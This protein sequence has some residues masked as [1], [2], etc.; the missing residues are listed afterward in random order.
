M[1]ITR[2]TPS[3]LLLACGVNRMRALSFWG[4]FVV[5]CAVGPFCSVLR[6]QNYLTSTGV[7]SFTVPYPAEMGTVD[8]ASGNLHLE[9][10]L[11]SFPQRKSSP[12]VPKLLY[13][14]HIW[15]VPSDSVSPTWT[16]QGA[17]YGLAFGTWGFDEG[18]TIGIYSLARGGPN[19]CNDDY[20]MWSNSG[21][22]HYFNIPGY[23]INGDQCSG[24]VAYAADSSG[25]QLTQTAWGSGLDAQVYIYAPDGTEVYGTNLYPNSIASKDS[26]GN[27]LGLTY[28][29]ILPPGIDNPV[30]D[31][32]GRKIVNP[33]GVGETTITLQLM[34]AEGGLSDYIVTTATIP[35]STD[36]EQSGIAECNSSNNCTAQVITSIALP[37]GTSYSFLY[38]CYEAGNSACN[39]PEGQ[40]GY[41]GTL[42]SM[43]LPSGATITYQYENYTDAI[44]NVS[45]WLTYKSS[46]NGLWSYFPNVTSS[47]TQQV[48][49]DKP[50]NLQ[51]VISFTL[52]N[53]AWPTQV[54]TYDL[55]Y[56]YDGPL[57]SLLSTVNNTWDFSIPCTLQI[58]LMQPVAGHQDI[59]KLSTS[60]TLP[61]PTGSITKQTT[62][63][64]DSP[65]TGN[66]T[67]IQEWKYQPGTSPTFPTVPDR[68][69]YSRY[70]TIGSN[71]DIN[72]PLSVTLCNSSGGSG[73]D[74]NCSTGGTSIGGTTVARTVYTYDAYGTNGSLALASVTGVENHDDTNFGVGYTARGNATQI[75]R[76]V[77][78][79]ANG[80]GTYLITA[81][82]YDTTGQVIQVLD[83]NKNATSYLYSDNLYTDN[84]ADPPQVFTPAKPTHAYITTVTDTVGSAS[85][86]YYFGNGSMAL[87]TDYNAVTTYAHYL[88]PFNRPTET[89]YPVG[90]SINQYSLPVQGETEV[91]S[92]AAIGDVKASASCVSCT[93]TQALLD[94]FG[95]VTTGNLVNNPAGEVS[96]NYSY[97]GLNRVVS[98]SHPHIGAGDPNNVSELISY[99]SLG[100]IIGD[101]HPDGEYALSAY[102]ANVLYLG[103]LSAQQASG[104]TYGYGFPVISVDEAGRQKQQWIDGFGRVIEVDE[105]SATTSSPGSGSVVIAQL[106]DIYQNGF[107]VV[108]VNDFI[109]AV[110]YPTSPTPAQ[111]AS[112]IAAGFNGDVLS[113]VNAM[114]NGA[115]VELTARSTGLGTDYSLSAEI[116]CD[117][118][119]CTGGPEYSVTASGASLT[120][121]SGGVTVAPNVTSYIYDVRGNLTGV[122][123]GVQTRT[124]QYDALGR[125]TLEKTPEAST[126]TNGV[127]VQNPVTVS[128]TATGGALCSGKPSNPC[129][130]TDARG[131]ITTY[132]YDTANRLIGKTHNP[133]TTGPETYT[134]G[135]STTAFN[136]GRLKK[137]TDPSGSETYTYDNMGRITSIGKAVGSTTYTTHY[138]YNTG[139]QLT[140]LTYPSGRIVEYSYDKVGHLCIVAVSATA[141]CAS[142][143]SPYLTL[144]SLNYDAASRALNA[145][146]GNGIV[147]TATYDP[148]RSQLTT[149]NYAMGGTTLFGLKY[150]YQK[151]STSCSSGSTVGNDGEIQCIADLS[152]GTGDSGRS[153]AYTY[154]AL[155]RLLT[156]NSAGSTQFPAWGLSE[157]YDRYANRTIQT[158]T[159]GSGYNTSLT[160][161]PASNQVTSPAF[162]YDAGGDVTAEPAPLPAT[163]SYDGESCMIGFIG[164]GNSATYTCDGH[165]VRVQKVVTGTN[166]V[167]TVSIRS[168][169]EV[170]A[171]YDNGA[172]VTSPTREYIFGRHRVATVVGSVSGSGGTITY[173]HRDH[174]SPRLY[175][176]SNG[177][178]TCEQGTYP[179]G[180]AWYKTCTNWIFTTYERDQ[181]SGL[182]YALARSYSSTFGRFMSP[183]PLTGNMFN[184]QRL[185]RYA[186]VLNDPINHIDPTGGDD[187]DD[188]DDDDCGDSC[189]GG[190]SPPPPDIFDF[191][192]LGDFS[193][194]PDS[195]T[196]ADSDLPDAPS[197]TPTGIANM[198]AAAEAQQSGESQQIISVDLVFDA[199]AQSPA[200]GTPQDAP[201]TLSA[202]Q[203]I[204][205]VA[206]FI[207]VIGDFANLAN[208]G[209][210][211][212]QGHYGQALLFGFSAIPVAGVL[213]EIGQAAEVAEEIEQ[214]A[215][216]ADEFVNLASEERTAHIL[217]GDTGQGGHL[218]PGG[219]GKSAFPETWSGPEVMHNVSD[220]ATDPMSTV[221]PPQG[222]GNIAVQGTRG[223]VD[224]QVIIAG[225]NG[226]YSTPANEIVTAFPT[227]VAR[228]PL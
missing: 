157:T 158:V 43:S 178:D 86:G 189:G 72:H 168:G 78:G 21:V 129:S 12:L 118:N 99:D 93:H 23:L 169:G 6:A 25:F 147:A 10:P 173:E 187:D 163:F 90:W 141:N 171:E 155:G 139:G 41:Y 198:Q 18:G 131:V 89:D 164:N 111:L 183:D 161:N 73:T 142:S 174:L 212:A 206:G 63:A 218:F 219:P 137:M 126:T 69:T 94:P 136:I 71:N 30:I 228:N 191:T 124:Y 26:N 208:A 160:I 222:N 154:D 48:V 115:T 130:I 27:Y 29:N 197:A 203:G 84:G 225:P 196:S 70:A 176:D 223:G 32:L 135:T 205:T 148:N 28:G 220:V 36:F 42:T 54:Q 217:D 227:N 33:L 186:Y 39:S 149:L 188:D 101:Q 34:N 11:G 127:T 199:R 140:K 57:Q 110:G 55:N 207:P 151:N 201:S 123:Q 16:T 181:E 224:I 221:A 51:D 177:N 9:I 96:V 185:N 156:A 13:D 175:T 64:Y 7:T 153:L 102:G 166:A 3:C 144:P 20:M 184:P 60:T 143:T 31:T 200:A 165:N 50:N 95:R 44:G 38:D 82:S 159:A 17:L 2:K 179:F 22:Q 128:Y 210:S 105:P 52:D 5:L 59:R 104:A 49:V 204:L 215:E 182:D 66:V 58:C 75:A 107:I 194:S 167:T 81:I 68:A 195:G 24:G 113:P 4:A 53:G 162:T 125:L 209:I 62:Y 214:A 97:N 120:G 8:A 35:L 79:C 91:D 14:S 145:T 216:G 85:I 150:Y 46:G 56:T 114:A 67:A 117:P 133:S 103:G 108:T 80:G 1:K 83:P 138:A 190:G 87:A 45:R 15:T 92:Y 116:S 134:Y 47:T 121:G 40:S 180:E 226:W 202:V 19:G 211:L 152:A 170:I 192:G 132:S 65:Q 112:S 88:D 61:V 37:D 74:S 109:I 76:C 172:A 100:R 98:S 122:V 77:T 213:G 119:P 193:G 106:Q 146:F